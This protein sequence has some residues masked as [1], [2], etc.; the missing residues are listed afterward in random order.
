MLSI[1][2]NICPDT[3]RHEGCLAEND[4]YVDAAEVEVLADVLLVVIRG[5]WYR[6]ISCI[7][8]VCQQCKSAVQTWLLTVDQPTMRPGWADL[9]FTGCETCVHS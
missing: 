7:E 6:H 5:F 8:N 3:G 9:R 1:C 4:K 2:P